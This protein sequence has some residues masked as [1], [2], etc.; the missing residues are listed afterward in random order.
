MSSAHSSGTRHSPRVS[1]GLPPIPKT[2]ALTS[3]TFRPPPLDGSLTIP[4][5]Y[6]WHYE[7]SPDHPLFIYSDDDG[8]VTTIKWPQAV[9]A[10][11]RAG[12][13]ARELARQ[14]QLPTRPVFA[15]LA[16]NGIV[17]AAAYLTPI[18]DILQC[19]DRKDLTANSLPKNIL[20]DGFGRLPY[21][22]AG[23]FPGYCFLSGFCSQLLTV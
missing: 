4:E 18:A 5:L 6:D 8:E 1:L 10:V 12:H 7:N 16:G 15:I 23:D 17:Y 22:H 21:S 11:H 2:Q 3:T 19:P 14:N 20:C 9:R 13:M